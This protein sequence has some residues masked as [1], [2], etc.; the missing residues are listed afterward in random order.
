[1]RCRPPWLGPWA[2]VSTPRC[3]CCR[4]GQRQSKPELFS[5]P[6]RF[7]LDPQGKTAPTC[8]EHSSA[9]NEPGGTSMIC[10]RRCRAVPDENMDEP[11]PIGTV[12][13]EPRSPRCCRAWARW[14]TAPRSWPAC[15]T[16]R[17]D[18]CKRPGSTTSPR[19]TSTCSVKRPV[20]S[21]S[22]RYD[23][24]GALKNH[25]AHFERYILCNIGSSGSSVS[26]LSVFTYS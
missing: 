22:C 12:S 10:G 26:S 16:P 8:P 1:M 23:F 14:S 3:R 2:G 9:R 20:P 21:D 11:A 24:S 13:P 4:A 7:L 18:C 6:E 19:P 17:S 25:Y 15:A 5:Q